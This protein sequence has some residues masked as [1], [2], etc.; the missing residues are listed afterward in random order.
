MMT[1][2]NAQSNQQPA[3]LPAFDFSFLPP[4]FI[5]AMKVKGEHNGKYK[6]VCLQ[7]QSFGDNIHTLLSTAGLEAHKDRFSDVMLQLHE[8][9]NQLNPSSDYCWFPYL[10]EIYLYNKPL[11]EGLCDGD[12]RREYLCRCVQEAL[13]NKYNDLR[14][15]YFRYDIMWCRMLHH[16]DEANRRNCFDEKYR[17]KRP[18][19]LTPYYWKLFLRET[20]RPSARVVIRR[21]YEPLSSDS[22]E[23]EVEVQQQPQP[24]HAEPVAELALGLAEPMP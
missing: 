13:Y 2:M 16:I 3:L 18:Y 17:Y 15:T 6:P 4:S 1:E 5:E 22:E 8:K 10:K 19:K 21:E 20:P 7:I 9:K 14:L 11:G 24:I 23:E 12:P